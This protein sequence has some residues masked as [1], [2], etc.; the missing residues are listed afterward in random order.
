MSYLR[1]W[2]IG[3]AVGLKPSYGGS[4]PPF[5]VILLALARRL[6]PQRCGREEG[7]RVVTQRS[8]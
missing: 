6:A 7:I 4:I 5:L 3:H 8:S 2:Q 1:K